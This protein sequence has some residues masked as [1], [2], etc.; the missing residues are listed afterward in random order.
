MTLLFYLEIFEFNFCSLNKNTKKNIEEREKTL[1]SKNSSENNI[2]PDD[3]SEIE[4]KGYIIKD[5]TKK[6]VIEMISPT[7]KSSNLSI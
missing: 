2:L 4:I 7:E 3:E 6:S 5:D 1:S